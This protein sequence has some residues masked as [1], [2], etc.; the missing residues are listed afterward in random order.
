M[1]S[2]P[3]AVERMELVSKL[4]KTYGYKKQ[5]IH[6]NSRVNRSCN[7][8]VQGDPKRKTL[9]DFALMKDENRDLKHT[10]RSTLA[11]KPDKKQC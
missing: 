9:L 10:S 11:K 5:R 8:S 6:P 4:E 1:R 2:R 7:F 3:T